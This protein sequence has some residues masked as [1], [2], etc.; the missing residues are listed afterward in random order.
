MT[1][2]NRPDETLSSSYLYRGVIVNVRQDMVQTAGGKKAFREI[3]EHPGAVAILAVDRQG[4]I[5]MVKQYRQPAG[6]FMLEIPA[7]KI[8]PGEEPLDCAKRELPEETGMQ[9]RSWSEVYCFYPS[10]GFCDELIYLY[11]A[12]DLEPVKPATSDPDEEITCITMPLKEAA[13]RIADGEITDGKTII[14]VQHA[15]LYQI[16]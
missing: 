5:L 14:A 12:R 9:G 7:G 13:K 8:E 15:M 10:P 6:K 2:E 11:S 3:V 4:H 16:G 1:G